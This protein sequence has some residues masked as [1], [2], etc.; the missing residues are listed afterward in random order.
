ME[1]IR[2]TKLKLQLRYVRERSFWT[3]L[4]ILFLTVLAVFRPGS[5]AVEEIRKQENMMEPN[6]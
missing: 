3:D 4:R 2:P 6:R 5:Q 1:L